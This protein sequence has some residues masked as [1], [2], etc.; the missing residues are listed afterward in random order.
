M[1]SGFRAEGHSRSSTVPSGVRTRLHNLFRDVERE[2]EALCLENA[3]LRDRVSVLETS[4]SSEAVPEVVPEQQKKVF[5]S[6]AAAK[7]RHKLKQHT[8][9][10]VSSFKT[11]SL[12]CTLVKEYGGH[13]DGLWDI[14]VS[15]L[16]HPLVGTA[17]ADKTA[18]IWGVDSGR[19]LT[20]YTG[21]QGSVNSI[22]FH[23]AQDLVLTASGDGSAHVWQAA[24]L[25]ENLLTSLN[26]GQPGQESSEESAES[27]EDDGH[28]QTHGQQQRSWHTVR[29][30]ITALTGHQGVV[31]CCQWLDE[32]LAVT[33]GWDRTANLYNVETGGL[34]QTL[35][36]H[37]AELTHV[38]CHPTQRLVA[39]CSIDS[40]F[41]LWDFR[42]NIHSVSVFQGHT[43]S[44]TCACFSRSEQIV[45][46]SDD[47]SVKVW[48]L[49]N[50][51]APV[52]SIQTPS[53]VNRLSVSNTG[54]IAIPQDNR[55]VV[56]HELLSGQKLCRLP[57]DSSKS[58]HRMVTATC[59][60]D[61][62]AN[63]GKPWRSFANLFS[64]GFDRLAF[65]WAVR[66][67]AKDDLSR[68]VKAEKAGKSDKDGTF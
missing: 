26:S 9:K 46:G 24:V 1:E 63:G 56:I 57:R 50:M 66:P 19:C 29:T 47:R 30:P 8:S 38:A 53:A 54:L 20:V 39:T 7:T 5:K 27:S 45:S 11:P 3:L 14:A 21:H 48:D 10:I 4:K 37:D 68:G 12:T 36:G 35:A 52:T 44:V 60:A 58:H 40:T 13:R 65:G 62:D 28:G 61:G 64:A 67:A 41:R 55:H 51:R 49:R 22:A 6:K 17:S 25:P 18:R 23:P 59:W 32:D 2:F 16:G 15:R 33:A 43:E 34:L 42:E 31:I